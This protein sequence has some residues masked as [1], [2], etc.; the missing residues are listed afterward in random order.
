MEELVVRTCYNVNEDDIDGL[1]ADNPGISV[2]WDGVVQYLS[3]R[4]VF[5]ARRGHN[6]SKT[7]YVT[8]SQ[9]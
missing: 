6:L 1:R 3:T 7:S 2:V 9:S 4:N 8:A 5:R